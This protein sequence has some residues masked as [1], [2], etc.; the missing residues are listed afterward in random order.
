ML[1]TLVLLAARVFLEEPKVKVLELP[2]VVLLA[3]APGPPAPLPPEE[4]VLL[5]GRGVAWGSGSL[6]EQADL[7]LLE[8][9]GDGEILRPE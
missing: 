1:V 4:K 6:E 3:G 2:G 9:L 8:E 5:E 7:L